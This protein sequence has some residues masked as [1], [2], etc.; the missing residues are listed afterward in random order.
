MHITL[1]GKTPSIPKDP[2][3]R[4]IMWENRANCT[5][6][7]DGFIIL[8]D[9]RVTPCEELYDH[10]AFIMGDLKIQSIMEIWNSPNAIALNFP[11]QSLVNDGPCQSCQD[12]IQCNS[13]KGR[14]WRDILKAYGLN[15]SHYPDPRCPLA[16]V[17]AARIG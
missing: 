16:P 9:G 2:N 17:G 15:K 11:D 7:R 8:P 12:F 4:K 6:N 5:G 10:P 1:S 14:C 3:E 13:V